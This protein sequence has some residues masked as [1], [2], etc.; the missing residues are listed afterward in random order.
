MEQY[1]QGSMN[2]AI[3]FIFMARWNGNIA[4]DAVQDALQ[5]LYGRHHVLVYGNHRDISKIRKLPN[6]KFALTESNPCGQDTWKE[7]AAKE[8]T[9]SFP[10]DGPF[11][12]VNLLQCAHQTDILLTFDHQV[13]DGM[14]GILFLRDLWFLLNHPLEK[15]PVLP[16]QPAVWEIIPEKVAKRISGE[17]RIAIFMCYLDFISRRNR[18]KGKYFTPQ[19]HVESFSLN[20]QISQALV[21]RCR[22]EN[23]SVHAAISVAWMLALQSLVNLSADRRDIRVNGIRSVSS[24]V[25]LRHLLPEDRRACAGMYYSTVTTQLDCNMSRNFWESAR[26]MK[27]QMD[28]ECVKNSFYDMPLFFKSMYERQ[29]RLAE[30]EKF[31]I[32]ELPVGYDFSIS[33]MGRLD[34]W[35]ATENENITNNINAIF[36]PVVNAFK[37]EKTIGVSTIHGIIRFVFTTFQGDMDESTIHSLFEEVLGLIKIAIDPIN[38]NLEVP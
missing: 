13:C 22:E 31:Q 34:S 1:T 9:I 25:S 12:R 21:K 33:N 29:A 15:L 8:L 3:N 10:V 5:R 2:R 20:S 24:P 23:T 32:P 36:G 11:V 18:G 16:L 19:Y 27:A 26:Q 37:G 14:S 35:F 38:K 4:I 7:V 30:G 6:N 28:N 17:L